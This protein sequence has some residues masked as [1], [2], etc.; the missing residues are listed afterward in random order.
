[1]KDLP[2]YVSSERMV[3]VTVKLPDGSKKTFNSGYDHI[4]F[5]DIREDGIWVRTENN[6][7]LFYPFSRIL[8]M[9]MSSS[10]ETIPESLQKQR[11]R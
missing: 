5:I 3:E 2:E 6:T 9:K 4:V 10:N 7:N 8:E 1:M 11:R